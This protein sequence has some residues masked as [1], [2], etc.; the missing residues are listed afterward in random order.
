[1]LRDMK[2]LIFLI[3]ICILNT[4][5]VEL[6]DD[7]EPMVEVELDPIEETGHVTNSTGKGRWLFGNNSNRKDKATLKEADIMQA[8]QEAN[9][10]EVSNMVDMEAV[11]REAEKRSIEANADDQ[12]YEILTGNKVNNPQH[13]QQNFYDSQRFQQPQQQQQQVVYVTTKKPS[14]FD[15]LW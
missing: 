10:L 2:F 3:T 1:M 8:E 12:A 9:R 6:E 7:S 11:W 4:K 14:L 15:S 13:Q 5:C